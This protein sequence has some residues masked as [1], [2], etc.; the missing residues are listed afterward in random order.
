MSRS[1]TLQ[2]K[3]AIAYLPCATGTLSLIGSCLIIRKIVARKKKDIKP[4][5]R[6]LFGFCILDIPFAFSKMLGPIPVPAGSGSV[7]ALG[8]PAT[9]AVAGMFGQVSSLVFCS[10]HRIFFFVHC[11][12]FVSAALSPF[13]KQWSSI[14][15]IY[16]AS[17]SFYFLL[18]IRYNVSDEVIAKKYECFLHFVPWFVCFATC[19]AGHV[20]EIFNPMVLPEL[21]CWIG[22]VSASLCC[23]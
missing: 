15:P 20:L 21:G 1:L 9:C 10:S 3:T 14:P 23:S 7:G 22:G 6:L 17:L 4:Y 2:Q 5:H 13:F 12:F 8:T 16:M 11:V 19:V 18:R